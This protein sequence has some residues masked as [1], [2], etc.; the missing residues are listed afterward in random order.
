MLNLNM[1]YYKSIPIR[2]IKRKY[3]GYNAKRFTLNGTNQNVWVPN[4]YLEQDG[5]LKEGVNIDF[6]FKKAYLQGKF[7]YANINVNPLLW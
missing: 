1:Q 4:C 3:D 5:T 7:K 2:L 6:V